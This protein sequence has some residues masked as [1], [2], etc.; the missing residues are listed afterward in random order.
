MSLIVDAYIEI[1]KGSNHKYEYDEERDAIV[2]NGVLHSSMYYPAEYGFIQ[3]TLS[4][5]GSPLDIMVLMDYP[6]F[7][8]CVIEAKV[9]GMFIMEDD[10]GMDEKLIAIPIKDPRYQHIKT[11][12]DIS[13]HFKKEIEHFFTV[14]KELENKKVNIFGWAEVEEAREVLRKARKAYRE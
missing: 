4:G 5:D 6:T 1:P 10:A 9:I 7:P 12:N 13:P 14:Y 8:G 3:N 2:L 11:L